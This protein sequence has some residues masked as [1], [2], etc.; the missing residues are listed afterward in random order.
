MIDLEAYQ[1]ANPI[2]RPKIDVDSKVSRQLSAPPEDILASS[3]TGNNATLT[4]EEALFSPAT[5]PGFAFQH[6]AWAKFYVQSLQAIHWPVGTWEDLTLDT[7][8]KRIIWD[9]T[10]LHNWDM[11]GT[12]VQEKDL[13][14]KFI[15]HGP[16]GSGKSLTVGKYECAI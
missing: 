4:D 16:T 1:E 9:F 3:D 7:D 5:V 2:L 10:S 12:M 8:R 11:E 14:M 13:G 6:K 15:L